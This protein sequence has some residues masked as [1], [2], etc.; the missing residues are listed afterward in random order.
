MIAPLMRSL[1]LQ[2]DQSTRSSPYAQALLASGS[3]DAANSIP[4]TARPNDATHYR[5]RGSG[6]GYSGSDV[7]WALTVFVPDGNPGQA[8][9]GSG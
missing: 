9:P 1:P 5:N 7:E 2:E 6:A 4:G 3:S 8:G